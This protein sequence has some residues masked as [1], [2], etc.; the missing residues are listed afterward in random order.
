MT[1]GIET[2]AAVALAFSAEI[3]AG[4]VAVAA[5]ISA[6]GT[7]AFQPY[8]ATLHLTIAADRDEGTK[9][10]GRPGSLRGETAART[11]GLKQHEERLVGIAM[12]GHA[13]EAVD[14]LDVL[15]RDG[16]EAAV[17]FEPTSTEKEY[18]ASGNSRAEELRAI[19]TAYPLPAMDT[20]SL[21]YDYAPAGKVKVHKVIRWETDPETGQKEPVMVP[22][23]TPFGISTRLRHADQADAYG[24]RCVVQDMNGGPRDIDFDRA[25]LPRMGAAEIRSQLFS[26][27]LRTEDDGE[28]IAVQC[29]KAA[30]PEQEILVV[31]RPG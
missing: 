29:L 5:A 13:G 10:N 6:G 22:V 15:I 27:G 20:I 28:M 24:L 17:P 25:G 3:K 1:E 12:P 19:S 18:V 11:L 2:G 16:I 9:S 8:D 30:D 21:R 7:E 23:A 14:W 26:A 4:Q 31:Q